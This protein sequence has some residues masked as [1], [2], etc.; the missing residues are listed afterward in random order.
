MILVP[1]SGGTA[2]RAVS[3]VSMVDV[4]GRWWKG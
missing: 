2:D 1:R 4:G 3:E